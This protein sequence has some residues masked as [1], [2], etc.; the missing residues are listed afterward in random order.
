[1]PL[2]EADGVQL[3]Y[4]RAGSG[5]P[6]LLI[7]GM[8]GT[9]LHW[10]RF[11]GLLQR[12]FDT[13]AYD[14]RGVGASS[15]LEGRVTISQL[16]QDALGLLDAL[17]LERAHVLGISMGGMIAQELVLAAPQ[18]V[19][20]LTLGCTYCGGPGSALAGED[21]SR[22]LSDAMSSGDRARA[23]RASWEVNIGPGLVGDA[24]AYAR[25]VGIAEQY[26]VA[27]GVIMVQAAAVAA[28]DTHARLADVSAPTLVIHGTEDRLL[29]VQ[30]GHLIASL[31]PGSQLE[32]LDG[33]GHLFF[34]EQPERSAELVVAHARAHP[35]R[36]ASGGPPLRT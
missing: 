3:S 32:I 4:E 12:D 13:I 24:D 18:R 33:V 17:E 15:R 28:H 21:V 29:P 20:T 1:M 23:I 27:L 25:F 31:V 30:N 10:D 35:A 36:V 11:L 14:H 34:W 19:R 16:A 22:L 7:M 8:S 26:A 9:M 6:L 2:A 5:E